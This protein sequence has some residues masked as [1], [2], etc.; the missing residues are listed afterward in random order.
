MTGA[1]NTGLLLVAD[2]GGTNTRI[3]LCDFG[4]RQL[5]MRRFANQDFPSFHELLSRFLAQQR[6]IG[7]L[8]GCC[9]AVAGPV[10]SHSARLTNHDWCFSSDEIATQ[11]ASAC[12][13]GFS[14]SVF[15]LNDLVALGHALPDLPENSLKTIKHSE[16]DRCNGQSL[17]AGIGTGFNVSIVSAHGNRTTVLEAELGHAALPFSVY[18]ELDWYLRREAEQFVKIEDV[19]SGHGLLTLSDAMGLEEEDEASLIAASSE[20]GSLEMTT[21]MIMATALGRL[22]REMVF[23]YLPLEGIYFAGSVARGLLDSW[24]IEPFLDGLEP[25]PFL[26][27]WEY[28][29][30]FEELIEGTAMRLIKDDAAALTGAVGYLRNHLSKD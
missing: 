14:G 30:R 10:T 26:L 9:I 7:N 23:H 22:S 4:G 3:A 1:G 17:V 8:S 21:V 18:R 12:K 2:V 15:L 6:P 28:D 16:G 25:S 24:A 13:S 11:I 27:P 29:E 20:D 5:A 19:F